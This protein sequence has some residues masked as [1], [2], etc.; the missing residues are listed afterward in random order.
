MSDIKKPL[1]RGILKRMRKV[2][3]PPEYDSIIPEDEGDE[4][5]FL[6]LPTEDEETEVMPIEPEPKPDKHRLR[7]LQSYLSHRALKRRPNGA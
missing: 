4:D 7:F 5:P 2:I 3:L 6:G 1:L